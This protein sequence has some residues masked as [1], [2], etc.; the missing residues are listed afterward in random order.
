[1]TIADTF[2][3]RVRCAQRWNLVRTAHPTINNLA[4]WQFVNH[5][6]LTPLCGRGKG[7]NMAVGRRVG[8]AYQKL[9][10]GSAHPTQSMT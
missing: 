7:N 8:I 1:M 2:S 6:R 3:R 10:V 4:I 9:L 5:E